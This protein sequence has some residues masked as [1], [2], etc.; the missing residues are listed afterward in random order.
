M[1]IEEA[2]RTASEFSI[3]RM[4][5]PTLDDAGIHPCE[6]AC[7]LHTSPERVDRAVIIEVR[8]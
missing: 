4:E 7:S 5:L 1:V 2:S 8:I 6:Y 3:R